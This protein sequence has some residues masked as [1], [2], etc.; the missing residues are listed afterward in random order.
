MIAKP[1]NKWLCCFGGI[2][3]KVIKNK[4]GEDI[5]VRVDF[6]DCRLKKTA[7]VC[8]GI[9]GYKEQDVIVSIRNSLLEKGY[10]VVS[11]D[12]RNSLGNSFCDMRGACL[13]DFYEDLEEVI[14]WAKGE[15]FYVEPYLLAGFSLGGATA[16]KRAIKNCGLV[17]K[18]ILVSAVFDGDELMKNTIEHNSKEFVCDLETKGFIQLRG[19]RKCL[20]NDK[21]ISNLK[22]HNLYEFGEIFNGDVL[23]VAGENDI[24][25]KKED[26]K[27]F[28]ESIRCENKD[29][30]VIS[31]ASHTFDLEVN[32][33]DLRD[34][35]FRFCDKTHQ[36]RS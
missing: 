25:S 18:I 16:I 29:F 8:H 1:P 12:C 23:I 32:R 3:E 10:N 5:A 21:Y 4:K 28:F 33:K 35:I 9:I 2:M 24:V 20:L 11:F 17:N 31:N 19:E 30:F 14:E 34:K 27:R 26:A 15:N 13:D 7:F 6:C 36:E 22:E